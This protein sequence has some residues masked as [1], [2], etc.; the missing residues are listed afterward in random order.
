MA[1]QLKLYGRREFNKALNRDRSQE[2]FKTNELLLTSKK[3][4]ARILAK[5]GHSVEFISQM[6]RISVKTVNLYLIEK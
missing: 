5:D 2:D 1:Q 3:D 6:L 4:R